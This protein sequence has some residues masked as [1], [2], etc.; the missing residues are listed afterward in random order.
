MLT[1][2]DQD[3]RATYPQ[4]LI[5]RV[6]SK[7]LNLKT[8]HTRRTTVDVERGHFLSAHHHALAATHIDD[9]LQEFDR[10]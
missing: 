10:D 4:D 1:V 2:S 9:I 8:H 7:L 5:N 6:H 3:K